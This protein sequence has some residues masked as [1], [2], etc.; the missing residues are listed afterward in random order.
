MVTLL[1]KSRPT[2]PR[3]RSKPSTRARS[4]RSWSPKAAR[5]CRR[6]AVI[7][8]LLEEGEDAAPF[9]RTEVQHL[10]RHQQRQTSAPGAPHQPLRLPCSGPNPLWSSGMADVCCLPL[11]PG[12]QAGLDLASLSSGPH[13]RIVKA[14][15]EAA[16]AGGAP[17]DAAPAAAALQP[18]HPARPLADVPGLPS[19]TEIELQHAQV[20]A[21]RLAESKQHSASI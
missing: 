3:W 6:G 20:I 14:D 18:R 13:G 15:V 10:R 19:Y 17:A 16:M 1:P 2:R 5:S 8:Y 21:K 9:W 12:A 4:A 11:A 7:A